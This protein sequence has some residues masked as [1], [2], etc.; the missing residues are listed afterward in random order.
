M[1]REIR[2]KGSGSPDTKSACDRL[3]QIISDLRLTGKPDFAMLSVAVSEAKALQGDSGR[4][5][6]SL[7]LHLEGSP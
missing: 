5:A 3:S 6:A 2:R 4:K 7:V 1:L